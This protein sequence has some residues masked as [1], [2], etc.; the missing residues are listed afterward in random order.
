MNRRK[1]IAT[2]CI[3]CMSG[4]LILS[5]LASCSTT[6]IL[7]ADISDTDLIVPLSQ[8]LIKKGKSTSFKRYLVVQ[9]ERLQYPICVYR[10]DEQTYTAL[11]MKCTHQGAELQV[12]GD[13]LQCPAHG[14]EF[15]NDGKVENGPADTSLRTFP[16]IISDQQLKISLK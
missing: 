14:S 15:N 3:S 6:K 4:G 10:F 2:G 8:F 11:L 12:F 1:F 16:I 7:S 5:L 13:K 9:N